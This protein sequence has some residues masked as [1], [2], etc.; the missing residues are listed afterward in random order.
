MKKPESKCSLMEEDPGEHGLN[1]CLPALP[2]GTASELKETCVI[3]DQTSDASGLR[4]GFGLI[5]SPN[6]AFDNGL[7][8]FDGAFPQV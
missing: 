6:D 2:V 4:W 1:T 7:V 8:E 3:R 5:P